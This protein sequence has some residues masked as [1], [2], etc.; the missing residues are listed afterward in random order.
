MIIRRNI[1]LPSE[2][3]KK[4]L[5]I[6]HNTDRC[7]SGVVRMALKQFLKDGEY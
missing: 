2:L 4:I 5:E 1:S 3:D 7:Y 6:S